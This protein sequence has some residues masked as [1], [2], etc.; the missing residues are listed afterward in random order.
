MANEKLPTPCI[1]VNCGKEN[2][3]NCEKK[4]KKKQNVANK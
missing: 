1:V 3:K 4:E 2:R